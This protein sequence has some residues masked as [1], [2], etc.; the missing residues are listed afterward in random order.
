[1]EERGELPHQGEDEGETGRD[2]D[3]KKLEVR[4]LTQ[5]MNIHHF[6]GHSYHNRQA[7]VNGAPFYLSVL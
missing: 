2:D 3:S 5:N 4:L 6:V 1:M 7:R